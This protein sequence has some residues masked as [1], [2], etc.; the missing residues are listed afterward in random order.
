M[1][2]PRNRATAMHFAGHISILKNGW[3]TLINSPTR[4]G[5]PVCSTRSVNALWTFDCRDTT[6]KRCLH[7]LAEHDRTAAEATEKGSAER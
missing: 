1:T 2:D 7:L 5:T 6:C 4:G 3:R